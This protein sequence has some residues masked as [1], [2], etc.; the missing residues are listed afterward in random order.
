MAQPSRQPACTAREWGWSLTFSARPPLPA[1]AFDRGGSALGKPPNL[2]LQL[3]RRLEAAFHSPVAPARCQAA[4]PGSSF[5]ARLFDAAPCFTPSPF[6]FGFPASPGCTPA[7]GGS[8]PATRC[9]AFPPGALRGAR[10][11]LPVRTLRSLPLVARRSS[12]PRSPPRLNVRS[13][14]SPLEE[15]VLWLSTGG[16]TLR[17]HPVSPGS[18]FL[19]TSWNLNYP[20]LESRRSQ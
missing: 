1:A 2:N 16:S 9:L 19:K 11:A 8:L 4:A 5:P 15:A 3:D 14:Y 18:L 7:R 20:A 17:V 6:G 13:L 12:P 10:G